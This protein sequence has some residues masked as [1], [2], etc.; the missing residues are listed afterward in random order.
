MEDIKGDIKTHE[1]SYSIISPVKLDGSK[2]YLAWSRSCLL[3]I[4]A[5]RLYKYLIGEKQQTPVTDIAYDQ[6][7][8][9]TSLV[10]S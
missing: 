9:E 5:W 6:W 1:N 3:F 4:K 2:T 7:E 8:V 10:M